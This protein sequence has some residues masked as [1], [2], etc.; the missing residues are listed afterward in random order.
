[1]SHLDYLNENHP[2][3]KTYNEKWD[4]ITYTKEMLAKKG[5]EARVEQTENG[6]NNNII[7]GEPTKARVVFVAHYDTPAS[8]LFP[9]IMIPKNRPLFYLYQFT[10]V[11]LLLLVSVTLA[12]VLS[13]YVLKVPEQYPLFFMIFYFGIFYLM[14]LAFKNPYNYNDNTSGVATVLGIIDALSEAER[15]KVAFILF[16]NEEKGK[17]GSSAYFKD[18]KEEM[19]DKLVINFDCVGN[20]ENIIFIAQN[21]AFESE[22]FKLLKSCITT[23]DDFTV[24]LCS[25]KEGDSNSDHKSFPKGVGCVACKKTK[26]GLL[27]TPSIHTPRDKVAN[28]KNIDY[29]VEIAKSF[30]RIV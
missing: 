18:H 6:K 2:A 11:I 9:N 21:K 30:V 5:I 23:S 14:M 28:N 22:E 15:E 3:R 17:K 25:Q 7:V 29:I 13:N 10:P 4:F 26:D 1:M 16:D 27:Y 24:E 12:F 19:K 20:G 8:S